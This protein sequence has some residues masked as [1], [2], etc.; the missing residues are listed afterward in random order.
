MA[1][2]MKDRIKVLAL[3]MLLTII[4]VSAY[5]S[6]GRVEMSPMAPGPFKAKPIWG[7]DS[8]IYKPMESEDKGIATHMRVEDEGIYVNLSSSVSN[9][10]PST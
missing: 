6:L 10:T 5:Q 1:H 3:I 4:A 8:G 7:A 9:K 2:N